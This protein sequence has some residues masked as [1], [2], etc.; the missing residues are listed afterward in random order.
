MDRTN[1]SV[2]SNKCTWGSAGNR[3]LSPHPDP[4]A[5]GDRDSN[6]LNDMHCPNY[7]PP[8][9]DDLGSELG[10]MYAKSARLQPSR[11]DK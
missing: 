6:A 11:I 4:A 5:A 3:P 7:P 2:S 1:Q 10:D 9:A 8:N